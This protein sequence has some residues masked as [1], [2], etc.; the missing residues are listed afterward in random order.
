MLERG[1]FCKKK[2]KRKEKKI[3]YVYIISQFYLFNLGIF[4]LKLRKCDKWRYWYNVY[5]LLNEEDGM[6][7][8]FI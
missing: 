4:L 2:K 8:C 3:K 6:Y 5:L 7:V 1:K